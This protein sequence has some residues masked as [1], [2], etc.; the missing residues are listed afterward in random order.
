MINFFL[1]LSPVKLLALTAYGEARGENIEGMKAVI[2]VILN[3]VK[4][5]KRFADK[6]LLS[7]SPY[8]AVILK[9]YQFSMY[10]SEDPQ[11]NRIKTISNN[12]NKFLL[13]DSL[14]NNAYQIAKLAI[15]NM[16]QDNTQGADHYHTTDVHPSWVSSLTRTVQIGRHIFYKTKGL[17]KQSTP[18]ISIIILSILGISLYLL[19]RK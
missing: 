8:H 17:L 14:L 15:R 4:N 7:R 16:L 11:Y 12:F 18:Y 3:R 1:K 6:N 5:L 19:R 2:N 10:N 9:P 13:T